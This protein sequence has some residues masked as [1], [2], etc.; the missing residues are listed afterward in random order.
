L[1]GRAN[2]RFGEVFVVCEHAG[3]FKFPK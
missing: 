3:D 2:D 1:H